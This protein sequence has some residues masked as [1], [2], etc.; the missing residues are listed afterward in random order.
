MNEH[1]SLHAID[2][3]EEQLLNP[4]MSLK[5]LVVTFN[6]FGVFNVKMEFQICVWGVEG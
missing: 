1:G 5:Y 3:N 4:A 6:R 2:D